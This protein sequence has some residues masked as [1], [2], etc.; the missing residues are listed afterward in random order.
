MN[1][2]NSNDIILALKAF[3]CGAKLPKWLTHT[4]LVLL[5]KVPHPQHFNDISPNTNGN[6]IIKLDMAKAYDSLLVIPMHLDE[7]NGFLNSINLILEALV[8]YEVISRKL[9][10]KM[11]SCIMLFPNSTLEKQHSQQNLIMALQTSIQKG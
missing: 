6:V 5:P 7:E 2:I 11:K 1:T 4:C 10:N 9:V 3:F 8:E